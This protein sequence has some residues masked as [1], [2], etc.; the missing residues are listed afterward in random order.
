MSTAETA[1]AAMPTR[2]SLRTAR[3]IA[4]Q[5]A[6]TSQARR[7]TTASRSLSSMYAAQARLP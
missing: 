4:S 5:A 1:I 3:S 6:W 7:P 2:P